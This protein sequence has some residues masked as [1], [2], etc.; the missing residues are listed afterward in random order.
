LSILLKTRLTLL[1]A[2][3]SMADQMPEAGDL[4]DANVPSIGIQQW[5]SL[6]ILV[7]TLM[8]SPILTREPANSGD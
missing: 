6:I 7:T 3:R 5:E 1:G 2:L 8:V 4:L